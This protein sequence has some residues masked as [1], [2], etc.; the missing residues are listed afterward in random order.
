MMASQCF[1]DAF[2]KT[3]VN[4]GDFLKFI[5]ERGENS[6]WK[7]MKTS[8]VKVKA[9]DEDDID[10]NIRDV[11]WN[12]TL[13]N[14]KL[15]LKTEE[16]NYPIRNCA[17]KTI[18]ERARIS[19]PAL[20]KV[21]KDIF[22]GILNECL[23][24]AK[25]DALLKIA[26]EK[27]TALHGGD[28]C[29]YA[30]LEVAEL[31]RLL[32]NYFQKNF[33]NYKYEGGSYEHSLVTAIWSFPNSS[34]LIEHY[35]ETLS[36]RGIPFKS[37][38]PAL[39]FTT[40]DAGVSGANL[41]PMLLMNNGKGIALGSPVKLEHKNRVTLQ[42]FSKNLDFIYP[43]YMSAI[44]DLERLLDIEIDYPLQTMSRVM[45]V[46]GIPK[47]IACSVLKQFE[48]QYGDNPCTAHD[49]FFGINETIFFMECNGEP[50]SKIVQAEENVA[51][52]L[53][54]DWKEYDYFSRVA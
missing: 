20:S 3:F 27:I 35:K 42:D 45:K 25:G 28:E 31:F 12:D 48:A 47:K 22:A 23:N 30:I 24:V 52:A 32:T 4:E 11:V 17:I 41:Y 46:I 10:I 33:P 14:T 37:L 16:G 49:L 43:K 36:K 6:E 26:D 9:I 40:S 53:K 19:G 8:D 2:R 7:R 38:V 34:K 1:A 13:Q 15:V 18:L 44:A 21:S 39:R 50:A 5:R 54:L 51:R 29:D